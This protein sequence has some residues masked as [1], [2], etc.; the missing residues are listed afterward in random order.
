MEHGKGS[1]HQMCGEQ[2][3]VGESLVSANII[4]ESRIYRF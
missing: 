4:T 1:M 2:W 3:C